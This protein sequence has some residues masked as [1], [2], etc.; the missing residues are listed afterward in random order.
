MGDARLSIPDQVFLNACAVLVLQ[1]SATSP[2]QVMI[3]GMAREVLGQVN[4]KI[5][6]MA[7]LAERFEAMQTARPDDPLRDRDA[8]LREA[9]ADVLLWRFGLAC[10]RLAPPEAD[11]EAT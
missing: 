3:L 7:R 6:P 8:Y 4:R 11:K 10:E 9:V 2:S 5:P 1:F